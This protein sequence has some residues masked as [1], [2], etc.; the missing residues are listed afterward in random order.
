MT[1]IDGLPGGSQGRRRTG[2]GIEE[3]RN[4]QKRVLKL[5]VIGKGH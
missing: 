4:P 1:V 3:L 2:V 5:R